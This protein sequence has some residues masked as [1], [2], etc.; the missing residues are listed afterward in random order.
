LNKFFMIMSAQDSNMINSEVEAPQIAPTPS[1]LAVTEAEH[2][3][4]V[5]QVDGMLFLGGKS[6]AP[7]AGEST[8][9]RTSLLKLKLLR[10]ADA[11]K[12]MLAQ[13]VMSVALAGL[14]VGAGVLQASQ[15]CM[16][17]RTVG[18]FA[19]NARQWST[20]SEWL[21]VSPYYIYAYEAD[22]GNSSLQVN[23]EGRPLVISYG[24]PQSR[25]FSSQSEGFRKYYSTL[26]TNVEAKWSD[27][28]LVNAMNTSV[29]A[30]SLAVRL[31]STPKAGGMSV[32]AVE[33]GSIPLV[34]PTMNLIQLATTRW[35]V[36][37]ADFWQKR[38]LPLPDY[39][40][41]G[42]TLRT[43][44]LPLQGW[45]V[46]IKYM[47]AV[48]YF[49][50]I[51]GNKSGTANATALKA[52]INLNSP[53]YLVLNSKDLSAEAAKILLA[54][55][56][57]DPAGSSYLRLVAADDTKLQI[58]RYID[59]YRLGREENRT[60]NC[61]LLD[62]SGGVNATTVPVALANFSTIWTEPPANVRNAI[63][64]ANNNQDI[65]DFLG[66][67]NTAIVE[68]VRAYLANN[69]ADT[70]AWCAAW[71]RD[72]YLGSTPYPIATYARTTVEP[73][74]MV[75]P[76]RATGAW[77]HATRTGYSMNAAQLPFN[78][79]N[80]DLWT[81]ENAVFGFASSG[82]PE[83]QTFFNREL[84]FSGGRIQ[85]PG[86]SLLSQFSE[87]AD[88]M[89]ATEMDMIGKSTLIENNIVNMV[90]KAITRFTWWQQSL[91]QAVQ[92]RSLV[93][94]NG[95][96]GQT[97]AYA[98]SLGPIEA[99]STITNGIADRARENIF[100][101]SKESLRPI[102]TRDMEA[103][104]MSRVPAVEIVYHCGLSYINLVVED[105]YMTESEWISPYIQFK[106][107]NTD[108]KLE[109][110]FSR[111][112]NIPSSTVQNTIQNVSVSAQESLNPKFMEKLVRSEGLPQ[113]TIGAIG[114][115]YNVIDPRVALFAYSPAS[116][117]STIIDRIAILSNPYVQGRKQYLSTVINPSSMLPAAHYVRKTRVEKQ[118]APLPGW[119]PLVEV[120]IEDFGV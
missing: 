117:W 31:L 82:G 9:K 108:L 70:L 83:D 55:Y 14:R 104:F 29:M 32:D 59:D 63:A 62:F 106:L 90:E 15:T 89:M 11:V 98:A 13:V 44:R 45:T 97:A 77:A 96:Q 84:G 64:P 86:L 42:I 105:S 41:Q 92:S 38:N 75:Y 54:S 120:K 10:S 53:E 8:L 73:V 30:A 65:F 85:L 40:L 17:S 102:I 78:R 52:W 107:V 69:H 18:T 111:A 76:N 112:Y 87:M 7:F 61:L 71:A 33:Y 66:L 34:L 79:A 95:A 113:V 19:T 46:N 94:F 88:N 48:D 56:Y 2:Q 35:P 101:P 3:A 43:H 27:I 36:S 58:R 114:N 74:Q 81:A 39:N 67:R 23:Y 4:K 91:S 119:A 103:F 115:D 1:D 116:S 109:G 20:H 68:Q 26:S 37:A 60:V 22:N 110:L 72:R 47:S 80:Q 57:W 49:D 24:T 93:T 50:N 21:D 25:S 16:F 100:Y 12:E 28:N 6:I 118:M 99:G 51:Y 5:A